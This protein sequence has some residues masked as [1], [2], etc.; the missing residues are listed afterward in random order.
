MPLLSVLSRIEAHR[1]ALDGA[2]L[3]RAQQLAEDAQ[4]GTA[5]RPG[6]Q[7]IISTW[8]AGRPGQ[9]LL[10]NS[11]LPAARKKTPKERRLPPSQCSKSWPS[12]A[13]NFRR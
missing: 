6:S 12:R 2:M 4:A 7:G 11:K 1:R 3:A 9:I 8:L 13:T 10:R 5:G